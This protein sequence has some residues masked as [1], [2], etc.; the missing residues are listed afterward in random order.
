MGIKKVGKWLMILAVIILILLLIYHLISGGSIVYL[1]A[2][3]FLL[4]S[5]TIDHI[6]M[7]AAMFGIYGIFFIGLI[8]WFLG[9]KSA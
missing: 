4:L 5:L 3:L 6:I 8:L 9:R 7:R 1:P 2:L